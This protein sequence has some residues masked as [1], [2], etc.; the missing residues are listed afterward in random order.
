MSRLGKLPVEMPQG[1]KAVI[2]S[3]QLKIEGP[4]GKLNYKVPAGITVTLDGAK[5]V[6]K[7]KDDSSE[8]K[9]KHGLVRSLLANMV[10]G[11]SQGFEKRLEI[12]GVGYRASVKGKEI[13]LVL[14]FSHPVNFP[15][16]DA[17]TAK[18][19]ANTNIILQSANK[20]LLGDVAAKIRALRPPEPYQGKGIKYSDEV[21]RRKAGK[22]AAASK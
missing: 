20:E 2:E 18:V 13:N 6:A 8:Q 22:A 12:K 7:R 4:K 17:V 19:E 14:G 5:L 15:L 10:K 21:I 1:V 9:A 3:S 11:V 16:P